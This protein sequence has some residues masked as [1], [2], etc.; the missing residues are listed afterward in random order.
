[1]HVDEGRNASS[2]TRQDIDKPDV[3]VRFLIDRFESSSDHSLWNLYSMIQA[4]IK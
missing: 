3:G 4:V 1:M 2:F